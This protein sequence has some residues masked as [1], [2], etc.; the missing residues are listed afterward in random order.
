MVGTAD[1]VLCG[2]Q[3]V[4]TLVTYTL[5]G[6]KGQFTLAGRTGR[7]LQFSDNLSE[8]FVKIMHSLKIKANNLIE[9]KL[10]R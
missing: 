3:D 1:N 5:T 7:C 9:G 4:V 6:I 2:G 8:H 10:G